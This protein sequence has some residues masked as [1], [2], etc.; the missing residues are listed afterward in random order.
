[1]I[2]SRKKRKKGGDTHLISL[3]NIV[4]LILVFFMIMGRITPQDIL[5]IDPPASRNA[6][7]AKSGD[8]VVLVD[9][10]GRIA[11]NSERVDRSVLS[12]TLSQWIQQADVLTSAG[13]VLKADGDTRF[14]QLDDVLDVIRETGVTRLSLVT[15]TSR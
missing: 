11:V 10:S 5:S 7:P 8:I 14:E 12:A 2:I 1:M 3:I 9:S 4:F 15:D 13:V 6:K